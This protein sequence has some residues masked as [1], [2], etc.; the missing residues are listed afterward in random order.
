M[1]KIASYSIQKK[2]INE[3]NDFVFGAAKRLTVIVNNHCISGFISVFYYS[4]LSKS[5]P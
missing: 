3:F 5:Y 4:P 1:A 2:K